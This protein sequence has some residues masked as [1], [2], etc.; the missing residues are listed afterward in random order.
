MN[1]KTI[2]EEITLSVI[3]LI[4]MLVIGVILYF[5]NNNFKTKRFGGE[6]VIEL[7][8]GTKLINATWKDSDLWYLYEEVTDSTYVPH[9]KVLNE[10]A[11]FGVLNGKIT[12]IEK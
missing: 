11:T 2:K 1:K 7:P 10:D 6:M 4:I 9:N 12:F 3:T 8:T 5:T